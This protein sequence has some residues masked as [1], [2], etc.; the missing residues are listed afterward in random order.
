[1]TL[2]VVKNNKIAEDWKLNGLRLNTIKCF[3]E[4]GQR[5]DVTIGDD[6]GKPWAKGKHLHWR[7][8]DVRQEIYR[9]LTNKE[10]IC[11]SNYTQE[12]H[13]DALLL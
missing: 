1:M 2:V 9:F 6:L 11:D 8:Q 10:N 4:L 7:Q 12:K 5:D 3:E 13:F